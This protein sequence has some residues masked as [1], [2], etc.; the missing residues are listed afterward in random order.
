M[1]KLK[2]QTEEG[3]TKMSEVTQNEESKEDMKD[4]TQTPWDLI[5]WGSVMGHEQKSETRCSHDWSQKQNQ[6]SITRTSSIKHDYNKPSV[7]FQIF[8]TFLHFLLPS[9]LLEDTRL[10]QARCL[11]STVYWISCYRIFQ[12]RGGKTFWLFATKCFKIWQKGQ[13]RSKCLECFSKPP[14]KSKNNMESG[15]IYA[16]ILNRIW[17]IL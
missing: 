8:W 17:Y 9:H 12:T 15:Q 11:I 6:S 14:H 5:H 10:Y 16:L 13:M 4:M 2:H 3:K 1:I 7:I